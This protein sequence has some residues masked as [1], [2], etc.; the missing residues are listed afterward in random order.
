MYIY[1][2]RTGFGKY[3]GSWAFATLFTDKHHTDF[4]GYLKK[5]RSVKIDISYFIEFRGSRNELKVFIFFTGY[6]ICLKFSCSSFM[7]SVLLLAGVRKLTTFHGKE[8]NRT[9]LCRRTS[10]LIVSKATENS[11]GF[12]RFMRSLS[13]PQRVSL[14]VIKAV[15][16]SAPDWLPIC[17]SCHGKPPSPCP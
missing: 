6:G 11:R 12:H 13:I 7:N 10:F 16:V 4:D 5:S 17:L 14:K 9:Y 3:P 1:I 2:S 15:L 8:T